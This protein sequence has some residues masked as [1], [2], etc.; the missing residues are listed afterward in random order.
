[1]VVYFEAELKQ[2]VSIEQPIE[3]QINAIFAGEIVRCTSRGAQFA[4][5][6]SVSEL[7]RNRPRLEDMLLYQKNEIVRQFVEQGY[8]LSNYE[9]INSDRHSQRMRIIMNLHGVLTN[10]AL[11][12]ILITLRFQPDMIGKD[13]REHGFGP[14]SDLSH[15]ECGLVYKKTGS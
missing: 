13:Y 2:P 4:G 9:I 6:R 12:R 15:E 3:E 1:M 5:Y 11:R 14:M 10:D 8:R 7:L